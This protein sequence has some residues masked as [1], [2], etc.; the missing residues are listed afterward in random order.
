MSA[1]PSLSGDK[2]TR[3]IPGNSDWLTISDCV[4]A[5][6]DGAS[7][8]VSFDRGLSD[9]RGYR[10]DAPGA[11]VR[12]RTDSTAVAFHLLYSAK[13]L[14]PARNSIGF[15]RVDGHG[16]PAWRFTRPKDSTFPGD[17]ALVVE[18]PVPN[19]RPGCA[20]VFHDYELILPYGDAVVLQ[21][22]VVGADAGCESPA[23]RP[24]VRW[25]AFGDSVTQGFT[26][27]AVVNTYPF[28][29]GEAKGWQVINA[30]IGGRSVVAADGEFLA[31]LEAEV[32][33]VAIGVNDWQG[34]TDLDAFRERMDGLLRRL[35]KGRPGAHLHVITPLW[36]PPSW[37]PENARHSLEEYRAVIRD[38]VTSLS[39]KH[40]WVIE[41]PAV[42]DHDAALFDAIAVHPNDAGFA[43]MAERLVSAFNR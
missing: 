28:I 16:E 19:V 7:G 43:Q 21:G 10:W 20:P 35:R 22:V 30:G 5:V 31:G 36:V 2:R 17:A 26:A 41:G 34:G 3:W 25:V 38:V 42:I 24:P 29:V 4:S 8:A 39:D 18:M 11:R 37:Q 27:S 33:S 14:G 13:H 32:F 12:F 40:I 9:F 15:Y 23:L 6:R 1:S